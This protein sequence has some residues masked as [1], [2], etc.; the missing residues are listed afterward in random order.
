[1]KLTRQHALSL[2]RQMWMDMQ[3]ELGDCPSLY[4][5]IEY[6]LEWC[7]NH[8]PNEDIRSHCFLCE[9]SNYDCSKCPIIWPGEHCADAVV[10]YSYSPINE[11][12]ALPERE[13]GE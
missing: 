4:D 8:F 7:T 13:V 1:M 11:I 12:L 5:R 10:N 9:Y 3:K 6:K 2:H